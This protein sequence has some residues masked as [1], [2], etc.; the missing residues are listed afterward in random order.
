MAS[1]KLPEDYCD[2]CRS[3]SLPC[4]FAITEVEIIDLPTMIKNET[5]VTIGEP[6]TDDVEFNR[7]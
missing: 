3:S 7:I 4:S 2:E 6:L 5:K 1:C